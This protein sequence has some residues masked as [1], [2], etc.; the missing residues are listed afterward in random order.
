MDVIGSV[1]IF[2]HTCRVLKVKNIINEIILFIFQITTVIKIL[3][4]KGE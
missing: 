1:K 2:N 4:S 3:I